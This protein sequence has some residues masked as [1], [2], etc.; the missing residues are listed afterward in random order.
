[1]PED[2]LAL[3]IAKGKSIFFKIALITL[4]WGNLIATVL[5]LASAVES[6]LQFFALIDVY[7][8]KEN[9]IGK[10]IDKEKIKK[11]INNEVEFNLLLYKN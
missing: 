8:V 3:G 11:M 6:I 1:M 7:K 4:W 10:K 2:W 9:D 5:R